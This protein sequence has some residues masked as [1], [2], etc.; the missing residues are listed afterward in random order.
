MK[1]TNVKS[2]PLA[3]PRP[4]VSPD[5]P[6]HYL[7]RWKELSAAGVR[8]KYY[9]C[10]VEITTDEGITGY[11]ESLVREVPEAHALIIERLLKNIVVGK[12]PTRVRE[13]W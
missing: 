8:S 9:C 10:M 13:L 1:V 11:G 6:D 12:D 7:P 2:Y 5:K 3:A 4:G